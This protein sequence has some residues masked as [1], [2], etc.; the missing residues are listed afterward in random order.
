MSSS[1]NIKGLTASP[2]P[3]AR[4]ASVPPPPSEEA[5]TTAPVVPPTRSPAEHVEADAVPNTALPQP[6]PSTT[7]ASASAAPTSTGNAGASTKQKPIVV[8]TI[9]EES[10]YTRFAAIAKRD[11][12]YLDEF[13]EAQL[14]LHKNDL[15][16][17]LAPQRRQLG[18]PKKVTR[19]LHCTA[20]TKNDIAR[21]AEKS[22]VSTSRVVRELILTVLAAEEAESDD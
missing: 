8:A 14:K 4:G 7:P 19:N 3:A 11:L 6:A 2:S 9:I 20:K 10:L 17:K 22:N 12:L 21:L 15:T 13:L 16:K 1:R 5:R 18:A